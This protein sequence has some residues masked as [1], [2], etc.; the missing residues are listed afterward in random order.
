VIRLSMVDN[1]YLLPAG[2]PSIDVVS[3]LHS[4][5]M[6]H[7]METVRERFDVILVDSPPILGVSDALILVSMTD[8]SIIVVQHRRFPGSMLMRVKRAIENN[9]G[10]L[11]GVVLNKVD[12]RYDEN[13]LFYTSY[14]RYYP[15][16]NNGKKQPAKTVGSFNGDEY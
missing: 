13:Y 8:S 10:H 2:S 3:L 16:P 1:L 11:L 6:R 5:A 15:K 4:K 12:V 14:N 7:L 9:G